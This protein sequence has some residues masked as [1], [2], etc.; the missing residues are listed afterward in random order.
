M[1]ALVEK[2]LIQGFN[3]SSRGAT[4][5]VTL[6]RIVSLAAWRCLLSAAKPL[7]LDMYD[8]VLVR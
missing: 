8:N 6:T 4:H 5:I 1:Q 2:N 3:A 7:P